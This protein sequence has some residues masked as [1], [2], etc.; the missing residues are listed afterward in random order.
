MVCHC[1]E[2]DTQQGA[3]ANELPQVRYV[4]LRFCARWIVPTLHHDIWPDQFGP[5]SVVRVLADKDRVQDCKVAR[6]IAWVV[7]VLLCA[8]RFPT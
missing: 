1:V 3:V 4:P 5:G 8:P 7:P 2:V 6:G